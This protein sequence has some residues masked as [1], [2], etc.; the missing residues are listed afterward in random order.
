MAA[1]QMIPLEQALASLDAAVPLRTPAPELLPVRS[2]WGRILTADQA[3]R[4]DLPPFD[5]S[6]VDG[7][8][9]SENDARS[10]YELIGT[11]AAGQECRLELRPGQTVKVM[12]GAPVPAGTG[13]VVMLEDA[14]EA[15]GVVSISAEA[16]AHNICRQA[17]DVRAGQLVLH[18]GRRL[19]AVEIASLIG[20]G[21][22]EVAVA[23]R[24]QIAIVSTGDELV[25]DPG[26]LSAGR[27]VN[28]NGPLLSALAGEYG[29]EVACEL[30]ARDSRED[31]RR[32][33]EAALAAAPLVALSGGVSA[34]DYDCVPGVLAEL[35][36]ALHFNRVAAKPGKPLT[37]ATGGGKTVLGLPGNPVAVYLMFHLFVLRA[38]RRLI[39]LPAELT[40]RRMRLAAGYARPRV[41]R[42]EHVPCR[43]NATG[44]VESFDYHGS[45]HLLALVEA[46]GF[47]V[48]PVGVNSLSAGAPI[49]VLLTRTRSEDD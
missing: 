11:V 41:D 13:R 36:L 8:A 43:I 35:G 31:T 32:A 17:E 2:A 19:G 29:L 37:L 10:E 38:A 45:A 23:P 27:I 3:A 14:S 46:D 25:D 26:Q 7:Y 21:L 15:D 42:Q 6:A 1:E 20:C 39:G 5:K 40:S 4:L 49:D 33:L 22:T 24:V 44:E 16:A 30:S 28:S 47:F 9:V 48:V 34:G 18:A 12:T